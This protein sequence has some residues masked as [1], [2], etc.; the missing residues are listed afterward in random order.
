[1]AEGSTDLPGPRTPHAGRPCTQGG[2]ARVVANDNP[3]PP[4]RP[5][6]HIGR[7]GREKQED[8]NQVELVEGSVLPNLTSK[9]TAQLRRARHNTAV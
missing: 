1:M 2:R 7:A 3:R 8:R 6:E 9:L 5:S 4:R